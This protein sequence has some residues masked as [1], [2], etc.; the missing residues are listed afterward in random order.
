MR[1]REIVDRGFD[2]LT[3]GQHDAEKIVKIEGPK[4]KAPEKV[5]NVAR[6]TVNSDFLSEKDK[7]HI[8]AEIEESKM[9]ATKATLQYH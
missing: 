2:I 8:Q 1:Y 4:A 5:W 6:Q 9:T 3:N 7:Q